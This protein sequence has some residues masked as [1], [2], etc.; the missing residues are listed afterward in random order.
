[1][2]TNQISKAMLQKFGNATPK[3]PQETYSIL[4]I[5]KKTFRKYLKN[6]LQ[7]RID[8]IQRIAQWL[9]VNSKDLF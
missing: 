2:I 5:G 7:P 8:E 4:G 6:E 3:L 1:M 9:G